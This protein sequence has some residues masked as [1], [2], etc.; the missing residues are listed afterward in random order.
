MNVKTALFFIIAS[1]SVFLNV[2]GGG[3]EIC[4]VYEIETTNMR[5][6]A[7]Q[8]ESLGIYVINQNKFCFGYPTF[9][10]VVEDRFLYV[11]NG[12]IWIVGDGENYK[13]CENA[14]FLYRLQRPLT[15]APDN[16]GW[17]YLNWMTDV[18]HFDRNLKFKCMCHLVMLTSHDLNAR[19]EQQEIFGLYNLDTEHKCHGRPTYRHSTNERY[20]YLADNN[21]LVI[22]DMYGHD[23]CTK[24]EA[25]AYAPAH[26]RV[27]FYGNVG[28]RYFDKQNKQFRDEEKMTAYCLTGSQLKDNEIRL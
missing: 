2:Y 19:K 9:K 11:S 24:S 16:K 25:Y 21:E 22:S 7:V 23:S 20:L 4:N 15:G 3:D 8:T 5:L 26:A 18:W 6:K 13:T 14:G 10:H 17:L 12:G 1:S 28:W 27:E